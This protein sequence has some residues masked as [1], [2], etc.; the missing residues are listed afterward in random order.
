[1]NNKYHV[2]KFQAP[3]ERLKQYVISP[4]VRLYK[5]ILLQAIIDSTN[6]SNNKCLKKL[7]IAAKN[8]IFKDNNDFIKI[9]NL[10]NMQHCYI[11][12]L[13]KKLININANYSRYQTP[14]KFEQKVSKYIDKLCKR[15]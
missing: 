1:M 3:F 11:R 13:T 9:C 4:D 7:E 2:I 6:V 10:S 14:K 5:A 12:K 15:K 8:W